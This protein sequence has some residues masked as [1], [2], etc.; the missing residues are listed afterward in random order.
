[1]RLARFLAHAGVASRRASEE[2]IR[3]ARVSVDGAVVTDPARDV[4]PHSDVRVDGASV[5]PAP[6][7]VVYAVHKPLGVICTA[8]DP[9][10]R[11]TVVSLVATERRL[12]PVG[13]LDVDSTGLILLTDDG[14]L[15]HRVTHP[16]FEVEKT[17]RVRVARPPLRWRELRRLTEGLELDDGPTAPAGVRLL[18]PDTLELTLREG[19]KRQVRRMCAAI[20]HPVIAL[21]R[22][23]FGPL[24][25]GDLAP[26]AHRRLTRRETAAL[27]AA[28]GADRPRAGGSRAA[29][30]PRR[31]RS[32]RSGGGRASAAR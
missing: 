21:T 10:G 12:Y 5:A 14:E 25:L 30:G 28:G 4:G 27:R 26:G 8:S 23:R 18:A 20:G 3:A 15:A 2:V 32:P 16:R 24:E 31:S 1:M 9:Q 11:R 17:Y 19:R 6:D 7:T 29:P 13:R 22:V